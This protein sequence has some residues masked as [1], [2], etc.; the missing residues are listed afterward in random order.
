MNES[1]QAARSAALDLLKPSAKEVAHARELHAEALV[2]DTYGAIPRAAVDGEALKAVVEADASPAEVAA[3]AEEMSYTRCATDPAE[4]AEFFTAWEA[5]GVTAVFHSSGDIRQCLPRAVR[6]YAHPL[7]T[8]DLLQE[9]YRR[10]AT[11]DDITAAKQASR[12]CIV[13]TFCETPLPELWNSAEEEMSFIR[14]FFQL[15]ARMMH[16][17]YNRRNMIG[18][19]CMESADAGL[20]DFGRGVVAEMN[21]VGV[22]VDV[23]HCGQR[24]SL[25]AAKASAL[26]IVASHTGSQALSGHRRC[27][28]PEVIRAIADTGGLIG[29][30]CVPAFLGLSG[31]IRAMLDHIDDLVRRVGVDHVA[32]GTDS[33][34]TSTRSAAEAAKVPPRPRGRQNWANFWGDGDPLFDPHWRQPHMIQSLA[35]TNWPMFTLGLVQR[36]YA[37]DDIRKLIGGNILRVFRTVFDQ[38]QP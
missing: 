10:A 36:G 35:W 1:I 20:S 7:Y 4:R 12:H 6:L 26:P 18:D 21:R 29:V 9:R 27:K 37:D 2:I 30:C 22:M 28:N 8:A 13:E 31:D 14:V 17:T 19:G 5:A 34:Y 32:I 38:R 24:T 3:L 15:G 23:A 11:P 33:G 16:L 25:E